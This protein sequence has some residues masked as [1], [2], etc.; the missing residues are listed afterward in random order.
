MKSIFALPL[1]GKASM[2]ER[3]LEVT[4]GSNRAAVEKADSDFKGMVLKTFVEAM[5]PKNAP[6]VYGKGTAGEIWKSY[7]AEHIAGELAKSGR[8]DLLIKRR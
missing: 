2:A 4:G 5:L 1:S 7:L 8:L 3:S 6:D